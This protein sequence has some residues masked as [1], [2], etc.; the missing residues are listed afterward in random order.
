MR[1]IQ[2]KSLVLKSVFLTNVLISLNLQ[3]EENEKSSMALPQVAEPVSSS[4]TSLQ[5]TPTL[6]PESELHLKFDLSALNYFSSSSVDQN[7]QEKFQTDLSWTKKGYVFSDIQA[8]LGRLNV[9]DSTYVALPQAY[10]GVGQSDRSYITLGRH[11]NRLSQMDDYF[12]LGQY[13]PYFSNDLIGFQ[14]QGTVGVHLQLFNGSYGF[15]LAWNPYF[16]PNQGPQLHEKNGRLESSNRWAQRVP[17][18]YVLT[19]EARPQPIQYTVRPY[20]MA[21]I[22]QNPAETV[23]FFWGATVARPYLRLAYSYQPV[24]DVPLSR[25]TY[26]RTLNSFGQV[27]LSP[28]VT[29]QH[30]WSTDLNY[31]FSIFQT[32]FSYLEDKP[33]NKVADPGDTLQYLNPLKV[34]GIIT[35]ANLENIFNRKFKITIGYS[36][37][38][39]GEIQDL[40]SSRETSLFTFANR[41]AQFEKP[42]VLGFESDAY[43]FGSRPVISNLKWTYDQKQK[44]SLLSALFQ[45]Q[46]FQDLSLNLGF[47]ILG[48]Q[49]QAVKDEANQYLQRNQA[50]DRFYGGMQYVF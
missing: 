39:G 22:I 16:L 40:T 50:N 23:S 19:D 7:F 37:V 45:H 5:N 33:M 41:R 35:S 49:E 47:D 38:H 25:A 46:T 28:V 27:D 18:Q 29:Y 9:A 20:D 10:V 31:D 13:H 3:A 14:D 8:T 48:V 15:N 6:K 42:F 1:R 32:T 44:G 36:E 11:I 24:N 17:T 34:Y 43:I 12:H 21:E 26:S 2:Y 30:L 4:R